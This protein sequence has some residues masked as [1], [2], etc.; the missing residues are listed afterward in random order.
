MWVIGRAVRRL[1][2][3]DWH[4]ELVCFYELEKR[5][6]GFWVALRLYG[7]L[8]ILSDKAWDGEGLT[9]LLQG[10][11]YLRICQRAPKAWW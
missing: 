10:G 4:I 6:L 3:G 5:L 2:L 11:L 9:P 7:K 1:P 8:V